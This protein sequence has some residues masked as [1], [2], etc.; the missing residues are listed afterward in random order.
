MKINYDIQCEMCKIFSNSNRMRILIALRKK[1]KTV[2]ELME[3]TELPQSV[4][5][6]HLSMMYNRGILKAEK[7][8]LFVQYKLKYPKIMQAFDMM[9]E[10]TRK[11][12]R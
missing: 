12:K 8:G 7:K 11:A 6:Q 5:S 10:I 9:R 2:S 4:I 1:P 3:I